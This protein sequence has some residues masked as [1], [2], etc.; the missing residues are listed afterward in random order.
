MNSKIIKMGIVGAGLWGEAHARLYKEH[1]CAD[2]VAV[3]DIDIQK[4]RALAD[5][6]HIPQVYSGYH[7]MLAESGC[8]AVAI[9]T[10]D[11]L[12]TDIALACAKAKKDMIIEKPLATTREDVMAIISAVEEN[13]VRVMVD[14]HNRWNPPFNTVK[15]L[16]D[17]GRFGE[18]RSAH[19]RLNDCLWV[20]TDMLKWCAKSSILWF[21]G[22]HSLDT[23]NW[24]IGDYPVEV[25][26]VKTEGKLKG[27]GIDAVDTYMTTI[28][29][30]GGAVAQMENSWVTPNGNPNVNDFK[31]NLL[32]T[33]GKFDIDASS[34]GLLQVSDQTRMITQDILVKNQVFDRYAGF[35]YESIRSF[36]D[37]L[38]SG[39]AFHVTLNEAANVSLALLAVMRSAET[40]QPVKVERI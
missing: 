21:L 35:A 18:P 38:A 12:H 14:L 37:K 1:P 33:E 36:V 8:D 13:G 11:F 30:S 19:F 15:Q 4:A 39:E 34:N 31:F 40:G 7:Q 28:R 25:Y 20:A 5:M 26:A 2:P 10:P 29:Y 17:S 3:C 23:M 6:L 22:S 27:L 32:C 16:V 24:I 9:V